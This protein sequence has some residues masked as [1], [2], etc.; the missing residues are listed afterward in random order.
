MFVAF[1][2]SDKVLRNMTVRENPIDCSIYDRTKKGPFCHKVDFRVRD[3][4][5]LP[6]Y[7][8]DYRENPGMDKTLM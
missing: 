1:T 5:I 7:A 4:S 3:D 8:N 2:K 6:V